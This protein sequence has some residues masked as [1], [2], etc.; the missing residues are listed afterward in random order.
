MSVRNKPLPVGCEARLRDG[1]AG[2]ARGVDLGDEEIGELGVHWLNWIGVYKIVSAVND[3]AD[4]L[5]RGC[6]EECLI[7]ESLN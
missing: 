2:L 7:K 6:S 4:S 1:I 5:Y 3:A